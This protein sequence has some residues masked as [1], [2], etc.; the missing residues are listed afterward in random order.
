VL[1]LFA[2]FLLLHRVE[3]WAMCATVVGV[4]GTTWQQCVFENLPGAC[5]QKNRCNSCLTADMDTMTSSNTMERNQ[6]DDR[7]SPVEVQSPTSEPY[8]LPHPAGSI[9]TR[10]AETESGETSAESDSDYSF[11][12]ASTVR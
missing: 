3:Y 4:T 12:E 7:S 9:S 8:T 1:Q 2:L 5:T 11:S 6:A 10:Q